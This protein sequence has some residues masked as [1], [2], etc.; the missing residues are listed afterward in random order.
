MEAFNFII[1][2]S[3][4]DIANNIIIFSCDYNRIYH[5][6]VQDV[7]FF[8]SSNINATLLVYG[9]FQLQN[10]SLNQVPENSIIFSFFN[11]LPPFLLTSQPTQMAVVIHHTFVFPLPG[12]EILIR[13]KYKHNNSLPARPT[14]KNIRGFL[15][16]F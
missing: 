5:I 9:G 15:I 16:F 4:N 8:S 13:G 7:H 14:I 12:V 3:G 6:F 10:R 11:P 1:T 2:V